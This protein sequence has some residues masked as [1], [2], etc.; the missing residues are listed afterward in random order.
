MACAGAGEQLVLADCQPDRV[1]VLQKAWRFLP[2]RR[3]DAYRALGRA[4]LDACR[5]DPRP[6]FERS[7]QA[8]VHLASVSRPQTQ[9]PPAG[10][11]AP[12]WSVR[13]AAC[14]PTGR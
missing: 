6:T 2:N 14:R 5:T 1:G 4:C 8:P 3:P 7:P 12:A 10:V 9:K 13:W 11:A